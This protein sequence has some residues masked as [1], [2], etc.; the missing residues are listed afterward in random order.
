MAVFYMITSVVVIEG[1]HV[2]GTSEKEEAIQLPLHKG[3][4]EGE[5]G[6]KQSFSAFHKTEEKPFVNGSILVSNLWRTNEAC[7]VVWKGGNFK[8]E[9]ER[10]KKDHWS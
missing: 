7:S 8:R 4:W 2:C 6:E 10:E 1:T 5:G 3:T 9:R